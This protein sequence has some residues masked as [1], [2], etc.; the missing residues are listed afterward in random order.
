[1]AE[2]GRSEDW[3]DLADDEL[4]GRLLPDP[5][6]PNVNVLT[7]ALVGRGPDGSTLRVYTTLQLNQFVEVPVDRILGVKRFPMGQIAV[8]IPGDLDVTVTTTN[9]VSGEFLKGSIQASRGQ[10]AGGGLGGLVSAMIGTGG[11]GTSFGGC[12][13]DLPFDPSCPIPNTTSPPLCGPKPTGCR[14]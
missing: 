4:I 3:K 12:P 5:S 14:C 1:M 9:T 2:E 11:G 7:G 8:W 6:S 10:M 13:T